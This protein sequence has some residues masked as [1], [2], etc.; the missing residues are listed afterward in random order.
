MLNKCLESEKPMNFHHNF[1]IK[2]YERP[3]KP[4]ITHCITSWS[5]TPRVLILRQRGSYTDSEFGQR[6]IEILG[7]SSEA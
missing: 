2:D 6:V 7:M 3:Y 4:F 1:N 5:P